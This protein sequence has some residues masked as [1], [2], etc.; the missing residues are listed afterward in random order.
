M[1]KK[2]TMK[3]CLAMLIAF[4]MIVTGLTIPERNAAAEET[5]VVNYEEMSWQSILDRPEN[6][7]WVFAGDSITHVAYHTDGMKGYVEWV[8]DRLIEMG[9]TSDVVM[10]TSISGER[11]LISTSSSSHDVE[12][13]SIDR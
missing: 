8:E 5:N 2:V 12:A 4:V 7:T 11:T 6:L 1:K 10:N 9:R 13:Y 3:R